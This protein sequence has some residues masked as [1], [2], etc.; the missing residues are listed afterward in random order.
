MQNQRFAFKSKPHALFALFFGCVFAIAY[1]MWKHYLLTSLKL[2]P[3]TNYYNFQFLCTVFRVA[4][5]LLSCSIAIFLFRKFRALWTRSNSEMLLVLSLYPIA[6]FIFKNLALTLDETPLRHFGYELF[7]NFF[8][9]TSEELIFRALIL[10]A[11]WN[12]L[13]FWQAAILS[14]A[15]FSAFHYDVVSGYWD[16]LFLFS[17]SLVFSVAFAGRV[18]LL[19]LCMIHFLWDQIHFGLIWSGQGGPVIATALILLDLLF[20]FALVRVAKIGGFISFGRFR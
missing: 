9:G 19:A 12:F 8:A 4:T 2:D 20:L 1:K 11:L 17:W 15:L 6:F 10:T 5:T 16:Y 7:F 18:G 3:E 13:S 14:S